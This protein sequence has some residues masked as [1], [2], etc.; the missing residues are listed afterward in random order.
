MSSDINSPFYNREK[1]AYVLKDMHE[2]LDVLS[3]KVT[4]LT[5][6]INDMFIKKAGYD[7]EY[8]LLG[9]INE[10]KKIHCQPNLEAKRYEFIEELNDLLLRVKDNLIENLKEQLDSR[11]KALPGGEG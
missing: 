1:M 4:T 9:W 8:T 11:I 5:D 3:N 10:W 6:I 2:L 7:I